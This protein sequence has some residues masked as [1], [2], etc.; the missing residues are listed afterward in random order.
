M[1]TLGARLALWYSLVSTA[2]LFVLLAGGYYLLNRHL[3]RGVD[4]QN[5]SEFERISS[6]GPPIQGH[7]SP[8]FFIEVIDSRGTL[9]YRSPGL[10]GTLLPSEEK[11]FTLT[12][13]TGDNLRV[14]VFLRDGYTAKIAISLTPVQQV[15]LGYAEIS[16][17]LIC[18]VLL[19]SLINGMLL[20]RA[21]LRPVR[22]IQETANRIRSDNLGERIPVGDV[23]D[24]ISSLALLLNEMFDRLEA[25]FQQVR[26]FSAEASHE[27]K[28][29]LSL[30]R[31]QAE[32]L[33][34]DGRLD[35]IQEEAVQEQ[36]VE[37]TRMNHIIEDLLFLSRAEARSINPILRREDPRAFLHDLAQDAALLAEQATVSFNAE[38]E[39]AGEVSFDAK[40][41]RQVLLNLI[42][43][44]LRFAPPGSLLTLQSEFALDTWQLTLEDE[45]PG[46]P[47]DQREHIFERF[48]RL[49]LPGEGSGL[50]LTICRSILTMHG[51]TIRAEEGPRRGGLR[52]ICEIP[53]VPPLTASAPPRETPRHEQ[54]D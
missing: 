10:P 53:L 36:L 46:V 7:E 27:L 1:S 50:G 51:G 18:L 44:A 30:M 45:G 2:T 22:L 31:L 21:A 49:G 35:P 25:S 54:V 37:I 8:G 17:V 39:A 20:S 24:E 23:H 34:S 26:R 12:L 43:N 19:I 47:A 9:L 33:L 4:L 40:L 5:A 42:S 13:D 3:V 6:A 11:N 16:I 28:T 41:M 14:G 48:V 52:V 15:M 32:K 29:P 38:I